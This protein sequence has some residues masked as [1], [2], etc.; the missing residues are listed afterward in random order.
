MNK[1][2]YLV[3]YLEGKD[4]TTHCI[5]YYGLFSDWEQAIAAAN[6][7]GFCKGRTFTKPQE[8][9]Y[10]YVEYIQCIDEHHW[11]SIRIIRFKVNE[12]TNIA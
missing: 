10:P 8:G 4:D 11:Q 3:Q 1:E 2:V 5:M 12:R 9:K 6:Q 7:Y